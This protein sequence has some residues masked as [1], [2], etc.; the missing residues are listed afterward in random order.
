LLNARLMNYIPA[1]IYTT[2]AV[3]KRSFSFTCEQGQVTLYYDDVEGGILSSVLH[4]FFQ[5]QL[6]IQLQEE[7]T[8][9]EALQFAVCHMNRMIQEF[10]PAKTKTPVAG[11]PWI[12]F[13]RSSTLLYVL[14]THSYLFYLVNMEH[15]M[16]LMPQP[17][18]ACTVIRS[19]QESIASEFCLLTIN[20]AQ[21]NGQHL[22]VLPKAEGERSVVFDLP[23]LLISSGT[24][25]EFV[26]SCWRFLHPGSEELK[27][28]V[29]GLTISQTKIAGKHEKVKKPEVFSESVPSRSRGSRLSPVLW[30][31]FSSVILG[32]LWHFSSLVH[33]PATPADPAVETDVIVETPAESSPLTDVDRPEDYPWTIH[34]CQSRTI[35]RT[36]KDMV[37]Q[38]LSDYQKTSRISIEDE[39]AYAGPII[40]DL[41]KRYPGMVNSSIDWTRYV[42]LVGNELISHLPE[43]NRLYQFYIV[44]DPEENALSFPSGIIVIFTG[45]LEKLSNEAQLASILGHEIMHVHLNHC[46]TFLAPDTTDNLSLL[47]GSLLTHPFKTQ[48]EE[49][50]DFFGVQLAYQA[51][52][53]PYQVV[54]YF[55]ENGIEDGRTDPAGDSLLN[56][57]FREINEVLETHPENVDRVCLLKNRIVAMVNEYPDNVFYVG[58]NNYE[59]KIPKIQERF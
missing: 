13:F 34:E 49:Q 29:W 30:I 2:E 14:G 42:Q 23:E 10:M 24:P 38:S 59:Q 6:E 20:E 9:P 39:R 45:L 22:L 32:T 56:A 5:N 54:L 51:G 18:H 46:S 50:A 58:R 44:D 53:S 19:P 40:R 36:L 55:E 4:P 31:L 3:R 28:P 25:L 33:F 12:C 17:I 43:D 47:V 48:W 1:S 8:I 27:Q 21:L 57:A 26:E 16:E 37:S 52:Y 11:K 7:K 15:A 35:T 41:E